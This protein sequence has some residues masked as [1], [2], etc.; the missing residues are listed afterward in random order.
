MTSAA[1]HIYLYDLPKDIVTSVKIAK[2]IKDACNYDLQEP[3]QFRDYRPL[4]S[5]LPSPF[6]YGIIKVDQTQLLT[7]ANAIKYFEITDGDDTRKWRCRALPFDRELLGANKN[8][9]NA[10]L[11]VYVKGIP[12][13]ITVSELDKQFS[14]FGPVKSAKISQT[15]KKKHHPPVQNGYGFVCFQD[16]AAAEQVISAGQFNNMTV[17]RYQPK[18]PREQRRVFNNIYV[19]NIPLTWTNEQIQALFSKYGEIKSLVT[20]PINDRVKKPFTFV[21]YEKEGDALYGPKCA[22]TAV[23]ELHDKEFD[24]QKLYVQPAIPK[25]EREAQV[26]RELTRFKNSKKKCN[27]FVK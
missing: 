21:C 22:D 7:I 26:L 23:K 25:E 3:V 1:N 6:S 19:K 17:I 14:S 9:T 18:D 27:L 20:M 16:K 24:G 13:T 2:I 5:G 4:A 8:A 12:S 11:N 10:Q 15:V